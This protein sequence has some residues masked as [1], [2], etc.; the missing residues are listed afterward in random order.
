MQAAGGRPGARSSWSSRSSRRWS[1]PAVWLSSCRPERC[2]ACSAAFPTS[3]QP[4]RS[5]AARPAPAATGPKPSCGAHRSTSMRWTTQPRNRCS[6]ISPMSSFE[7][8]GVRSRFFRKDGK[9]LVET[10]GPDGKLAT[11]EVKYTFGVDPLQ[12]YLIEFPDGRLQA[13]S[14]AWDSRPKDQGGQRWFHL[15]PDEEIKHD[16][17]LHW[18]KLNQNWNFMCAEC[19]STGVRKNYDAGKRSLRHELCGD[20]RG[21]RGVPWPGL[22]ARRLGTRAQQSWWP[23]GKSED[24][25]KGLARSLRRAAR[26]RLADRSED[27]QRRAQLHAGAAAQGGRDLRPVPRAPRPDFPRIGFPAG[28]C[29][30]RIFVSPLGARA[31]SRR[32]ADARRGLQLRL[33]QAEQDVR[34]RRHLQRLPRAAWRQAARAR[35]RRLPAMSRLRQVR[36]RHPSPACGSRAR[37]SPVRPATCPAAPTWGS[38]AGTIT[39]SAFRGPI[40]RRSSARPMPA[41]I[42]TATSRPNG[43]LRRSKA[44]MGPPERASRPMPRHFMPPGRTRRM[45]RRCWPIVAS[46]RSAPAFARASA[47]SELGAHLSPATI[48]LARAALSDPD[49]MVRIGALDMLENVPAAQLWPLV[50]PLLSD[51]EPRRAHQGRLAARSGSDRKPAA[52]RPR[53]LRARGGRIRRR[54][55]PQCRSARSAFHAGKFLRAARPPCGGRGRIQGR[56]AARARNMRRRRSTSPIS[57]GNSAATA[58]EKACCA[59]RSPRRRRMRGCTMRSGWR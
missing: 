4:R 38:I 44:G 49:P 45:R 40:C 34:G 24:P 48:N 2:A 58:R 8:Y 51:S 56:A 27:R 6:A 33:V 20:Q 55:A 10:D 13:L 17:V 26:R 30:T 16:D 3:T 1:R 29:P 19:H 35:R 39:A 59:R 14:I 15:Y 42:V 43:R 36:R 23:F 53:T 7:Y 11:F 22:A 47:L 54:P 41:M 50:S 46:D 5:S 28:R 21:L 12:Q 25:R 57:I 18:T 9:F 37:R 31:L 32:R 52:C